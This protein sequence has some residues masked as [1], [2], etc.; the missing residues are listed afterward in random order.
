MKR[1]RNLKDERERKGYS[2]ENMGK[3]I[4]VSKSSYFNKEKGTHEFTFTEM[5]KLSLIFNKSLDYLFE[6]EKE[7]A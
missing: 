7:H 3:M 6:E 1:F 5:K 2:L 4:D